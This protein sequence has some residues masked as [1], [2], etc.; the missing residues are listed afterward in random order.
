MDNLLIPEIANST[1]L[2]LGCLQGNP[3]Y[4]QQLD[5]NDW[6][7]VL[8]LIQHHRIESCLYQSEVWPDLEKQLSPEIVQHIRNRHRENVLRSLQYQSAIL[9]IFEKFTL[10]HVHVLLIKG[11]AVQEWL[12]ERKIRPSR[13]VDILIEPASVPLATNLLKQ[14]GYEQLNCD[15][16]FLERDRFTLSRISW[17]KD[18]EFRHKV[19]GIV[20]ELH[21]RLTDIEKE[22]Q[23]DFNELWSNRSEVTIAGQQVPT[24][25]PEM[26]LLY[27]SVHVA[28]SIYGRFFSLQDISLVASYHPNVLQRSFTMA[29]AMKVEKALGCAVSL[30]CVIYGTPQ[31]KAL[32][33]NNDLFTRCSVLLEG[34]LPEILSENPPRPL[35][36]S[37]PPFS[38]IY[39]IGNWKAN[40]IDL[41]AYRWRWFLNRS[42][43]K[44]PDIRLIKLHTNLSF[45]YW[46][47]HPVRYIS[48]RV[49][50]FLRA[51]KS[52]IKP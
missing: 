4:P 27:L 30:A 41:S 18:Q 31:P 48:T 45:L 16:P 22:F 43:P 15:A 44:Y 10:S 17:F 38:H 23:Y 34:I 40:I 32:T 46:L 24:L 5:K 47:I 21:W 9:T 39:E 35:P 42:A 6:V 29:P 33:Q 51:L 1:R 2:L 49:T 26:H 8:N 3:I 7:D 28:Q 25:Q 13:D 19:S 12:Y 52:K 37:S 50:Y 11:L 36:P 14:L 20:V